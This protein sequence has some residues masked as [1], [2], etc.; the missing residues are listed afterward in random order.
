MT[1][2]STVIPCY[3]HAA[4]VSRAVR[5][6][7]AQ[8]GDID[9]DVMVI[10]DGSTDGT[11]EAC[12]VL[13]EEFPRLRVIRK[14]NGGVSSARNSGIELACGDFIHFLDADDYIGRSMYSR[15]TA[16]LDTPGNRADVA[17]C[18]Y[19]VV[20]PAGNVKSSTDGN[21][22]TG[23]IRQSL[24]VGCLGPPHSFMVRRSAVDAVGMFDPELSE[25]AD[26]H[27]WLRLALAGHTFVHVTGAL[28]WYELGTTNM[29]RNY[30]RMVENA[31][32]ALRKIRFQLPDPKL[33][34]Y[35]L[36]GYRGIRRGMF[37]ISYAAGM[38]RHLEG[39]R[40]VDAARE[41]WALLRKDPKS[42]WPAVHSLTR[43]KRAIARGLGAVLSRPLSALK[44]RSR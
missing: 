15:M 22:I 4:A 13:A 42:T 11:P 24:L 34:E 14:R 1:C 26:W 9:L 28:V 33:E 30:L 36:Q 6:V 43:H 16:A 23:D 41:L 17:Y 12:R 21:P 40:F 31:E 38:H 2:V 37:D 27:Y 19:V 35:W 3:N 7:Y 44:I 10:D 20:D 32:A 18:G 29:S 8:T 39:G 25:C 5:S